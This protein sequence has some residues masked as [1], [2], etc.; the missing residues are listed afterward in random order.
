LA[1]AVFMLLELFVGAVQAYVFF[2]LTVVFVS[3]GTLEHGDVATANDKKTQPEL[4]PTDAVKVNGPL[5][6]SAIQ[7]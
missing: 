5:T 1:L 4:S 3:L 7:W 2:M 6:L